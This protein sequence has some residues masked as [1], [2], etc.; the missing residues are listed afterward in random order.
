M[1]KTRRFRPH[2]ISQRT[3]QGEKGGEV[4]FYQTPDDKARPNVHL[5]REIL[6][7]GLNQ[8]A[9]FCE[10]DK[11]LIFLNLLNIFLERAMDRRTVVAFFRT[12]ATDE[13]T[14]QL[15]YFNLR[16]HQFGGASR[17]HVTGHAVPHPGHQYAVLTAKARATGC[18]NCIRTLT[19]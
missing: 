19:P 12:S 13:E 11:S 16:F 6:S 9:A 2:Q 8:A 7:L 10:R 14:D 1:R 18:F 15:D 4:V 3:A 17:Q 5:R